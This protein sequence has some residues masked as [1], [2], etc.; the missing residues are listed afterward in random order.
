[1]FQLT[2]ILI[3]NKI[4]QEI[5]KRLFKLMKVHLKI[6]LVTNLVTVVKELNY[7]TYDHLHNYLINNH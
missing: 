2:P 6:F 7:L 1:M 4:T 3:N 5:R